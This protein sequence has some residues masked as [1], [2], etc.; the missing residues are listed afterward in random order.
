MLAF[1]K[2]AFKK[3]GLQNNV[4]EE[5]MAALSRRLFVCCAFLIGLSAAASADQPEKKTVILAV[6]GKVLLQY[7][8]L[9]IAE[10]KGYFRDA[11]IEV[12]IQDFRGGSQAL[13]SLIGGSADVVTGAYEHTI[14]M[15]ARGQDVR[16]VIELNRLPGVILAVRK[17][18]ADRVKSVR[19]LKGMKIG[20][21]AP[22]SQTQLFMTY[23]LAKSGMNVDDVSFISVGGGASAVS[24]M[25]RGEIAALVNA[26]PTITVLYRDGLISILADGRN[27]PGTR[28]IFGALNPAAVLYAKASFLESYPN[29]TQALVTALYRA[30]KWLE[31]AS[32]EDIAAAVPDD[33]LAGD[34]SLYIEA[35]KNSLDMY[36]RTGIVGK[37]GMNA[38]LELL[39]FDKELANAKNL[40]ISRTFDDRFV[41]R[42]AQ[43][44]K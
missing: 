43:N 14:R 41:K 26:E 33:Y 27:E 11:G 7:L 22:G 9:T 21:S 5:T 36:S 28:A 35:L 20:I 12:S 6:P 16:A 24:A 1:E 42:A 34:R 40:D 32:L 37:E 4:V 13:Q 19:D 29:T 3:F 15:L 38:A 17:D 39:T 31:A 25:R 10:R 8:P 44:Q 18:I 23:M 2:V 30:L